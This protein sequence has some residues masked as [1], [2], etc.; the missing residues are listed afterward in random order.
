MT[1]TEKRLGFKPHF[2]AFDA[3]LD[4]FYVYEYFHNAGGFAAVPFSER[5][6]HAL[7]QFTEEGLPLYTAGPAMLLKYRFIDHSGLV[8][9][10]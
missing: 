6:G 8:E 7:R 1:T 4:A 10:G 5:G 2:G 3:A 9:H